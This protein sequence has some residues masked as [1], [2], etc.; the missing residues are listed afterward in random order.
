[1]TAW[2]HECMSGKMVPDKNVTKLS[3]LSSPNADSRA[4]HPASS[5]LLKNVEEAPLSTGCP[6]IGKSLSV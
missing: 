3:I 4:T 2:M 6:R 5:K 1:M